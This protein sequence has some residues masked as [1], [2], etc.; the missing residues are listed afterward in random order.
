[1]S[2]FARTFL[3]Y[4]PFVCCFVEENFALRFLLTVQFSLYKTNTMKNFRKITVKHTVHQG[5]KKLSAK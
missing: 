3:T 1:M 4:T 2:Y 5:S